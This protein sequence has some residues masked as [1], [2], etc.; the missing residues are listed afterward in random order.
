MAFNQYGQWMPNPQQ[1]MAGQQQPW[2]APQANNMAMQ[3]QNLMYHS[4]VNP[5]MSAALHPQLGVQAPGTTAVP[6]QNVNNAGVGPQG[7]APSQNWSTGYTPGPAQPPPQSVEQQAGN[8]GSPQSISNYLSALRLAGAGPNNAQ[9]NVSPYY[10]NQNQYSGFQP[11]T[12]TTQNN[13]QGGYQSGMP[14][15]ANYTP[16]QNGQSTQGGNTV[17]GTGGVAGQPG[18]TTPSQ[19]NFNYNTGQQ[20]YQNTQQQNA[21]N[22]FMN[23]ANAQYAQGYGQGNNIP[24]YSMSD[25]NVKQNI[26]D[27][28]KDLSDFLDSLGIYSYEYKDKKDGEGRRISPMAQEMA[29]TPL[30]QVAISK[31]ERGM[32]KVD[33]GKLMGTMLAGIAMDHKKIKSLEDK[34]IELHSMAKADGKVK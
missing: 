22:D 6:G 7:P 34:I 28:D 4:G 26:E 27:G 24:M 18:W 3:P 13:L 33:Y 1:P 15:Q 29:K 11:F 32:M 16:W 8:S 2:Q 5:N 25:V 19:P 9:M 30:G 20:T 12:G 23:S 21:Y 17:G 14:N 10:G 31:D